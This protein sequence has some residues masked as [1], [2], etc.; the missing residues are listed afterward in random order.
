MVGWMDRGSGGVDDN[1]LWNGE[2]A[3]NFRGEGLP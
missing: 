2:F 3:S 1:W